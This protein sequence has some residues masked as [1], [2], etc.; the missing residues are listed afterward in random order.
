MHLG[1][2]GTALIQSFESLA[3]TAY[4][5]GGGVPTIGWGHTAGVSLGD[6]CTP[7][8]AD[9]WFVTDTGAACKVVNSNVD[10]AMTQNQFDALVSFTFNVGG[11]NFHGSTLLR[12]FNQGDA[13][14]AADEFLRW[15]YVAGQESDGL[16]RRREA[17]RALFLGLA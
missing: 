5:D 6:T 11:G 8:Q 7:A 13:D 15:V 3:L 10:V 14:G 17:E 12:K 2:P 16:M 1:A 4:P 9:A